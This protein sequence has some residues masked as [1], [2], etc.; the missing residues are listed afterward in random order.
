MGQ[1]L[2]TDVD[3]QVI[4]RLCQRAK[5]EQRSLEETVVAILTEAAVSSR[6]ECWPR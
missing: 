5:R 6:A 1:L 2:I 4:R 3:D